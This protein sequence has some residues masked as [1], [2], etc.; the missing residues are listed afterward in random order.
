MA[1]TRRDLL[2][3]GSRL[4]LGLAA[5]A[6]LPALSTAPA[7]A[8]SFDQ[9]KLLEKGN[10]EDVVLGQDDAPIT[11]IEYFSL[12]CGHCANFH[13][14]TF[15]HVDEKYIKTGKIRFILREFPLDPLAA[16][17]AM[18]ARCAPSGNPEP[19]I[20]LLL[21]TQRTWAFSDDPVKQLEIMSKQA[22][23]TQ[24]S[25]KACLTNQKLLDDITAVRE[26]GHEEF[27]VDSTPTFFVN[28]EKHVGA[29]SVEEFDKILEPLL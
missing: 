18:L 24:E 8:E 29:M 1:I 16:A 17:G 28:G 6:S 19:M 10:L 15:K 21:D 3:T 4:T 2:A 5:F 11:V 27:K 22:G 12:T 23:F 20:S 26:R 14:T 25:F 9:D 7:L 13:A